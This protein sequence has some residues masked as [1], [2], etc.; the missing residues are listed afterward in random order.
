MIF[1]SA[2][3]VAGAAAASWGADFKLFVYNYKII[4]NNE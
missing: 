3:D 1:V 4:F 2:G